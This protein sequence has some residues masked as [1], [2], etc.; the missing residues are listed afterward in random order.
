MDVLQCVQINLPQDLPLLTRF[1]NELMIP[2]FPL[3]EVRHT[4]T[5]RPSGLR[6]HS[7]LGMPSHLLLLSVRMFVGA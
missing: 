7:R 1:Y 2:N 4:A 3:K 5:A 6:N